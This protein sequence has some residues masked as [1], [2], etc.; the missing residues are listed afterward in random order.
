MGLD[1]YRWITIQTEIE[2]LLGNNQL[3][4]RKVI[5]IVVKDNETGLVVPHPITHFI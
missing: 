1:R 4:P 3:E 2:H 5:T